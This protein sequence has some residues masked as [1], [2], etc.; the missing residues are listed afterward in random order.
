MEEVVVERE[1]EEGN[2]D[3]MRGEKEKKKAGRGKKKIDKD[4]KVV[5]VDENGDQSKFFIDVSKD[6]ETVELISKLLVEANNKTFG[7]KIVLKDLIIGSLPKLTSKDIER[8]QENS[9]TDMEVIEKLYHE[10]NEKNKTDLSF[11]EFLRKKL[12]V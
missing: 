2:G 3:K 1:G 8:I 10:T 9:L 4:E 5:S 12:N 7:R 11:A 6:Q